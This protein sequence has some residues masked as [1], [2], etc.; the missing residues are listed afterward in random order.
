MRLSGSGCLALFGVPFLV[1]GLAVM[2]SALRKLSAAADGKEPLP[3]VAGGLLFVLVG[4][5]VIAA[6]IV[7][8][9]VELIRA[10]LRERHPDAP[11]RWRP[12]WDSGRIRDASRATLIVA[13][14]F[15]VFWNF[16]AWVSMAAAL[17]DV[18][19]WRLAAVGLFPAVGLGLLGW[20]VRATVRYSRFGVSVFEL[21]TLPGV[22]GHGLAG[23]VHLPPGVERAH[24]YGLTL[25]RIERR[26]SGSGKNR[27]THEY[28]RWE[29]QTTV[30]ALRGAAGVAVPVAFRIPASEVPTSPEPSDPS[31]IWRLEVSADIPGVDYSAHFEVPVFSAMGAA[32]MA[33]ADIA[34]AAAVEL[35][36]TPSPAEYRQPRDSAIRVS[37]SQR[38]VEIYYPAARNPGAALG[39]TAFLA[40]WCGA[41]AIM[42]SL[43][44]PL[45]FPIV[46]GAVAL[47]LLWGVL[48]LWLGT[49]HVT[50]GGDEAA[51]RSGLIGSGRVKRVSRQDVARVEVRIGMQAGTRSFY[52][53]RIVGKDR[54]KLAA[55]SGISSKREAEW[56][57][58]LMERELGISS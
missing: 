57:A 54:R 46:F 53:V 17:G 25:R 9:R 35:P 37:K 51:V 50:L 23:T 36:S 49:T 29:E 3:A 1:G 16:I 30:R 7:G 24:E 58:Q 14:V 15:A 6:A 27:S 4:T 19:G 43:D 44:A 42:V 10:A 18:N 32:G 39:L 21:T 45:G 20:A 31:T 52:D 55:G 22:V 38:G 5:A 26:T 8:H 34:V 47:L 11:W 56:L 48:R 2:G 28:T 41:V 13:W 33:V 40:I 12:E